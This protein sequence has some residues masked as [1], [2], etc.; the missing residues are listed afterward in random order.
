MKMHVLSGGRVQLKKKIYIPDAASGELF[1]LPV[2]CFLLRHA[3]GTVLF[4]TGCHPLA[5]LEG[6]TRLG[7]LSR[8]IK[9][10]SISTG[11]TS[12]STPSTST[13]VPAPSA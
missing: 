10:V 4:D 8:S 12:C 1:E 13:R 11:I 6:S 7:A 2:M 9:V 3:Q 5:A